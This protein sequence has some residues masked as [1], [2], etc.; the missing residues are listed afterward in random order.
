M[1]VALI[2]DTHGV[3]D[4]RI[5]E[6]VRGVDVLVHAGD[7]GASVVEAMAPLADRLVIVHGNNDPADSDWPA[8]WQLDLPGGRL[9]VIHGHQ[10]P[11][12][13]RYRKL[14]GRFTEAQA[15][16][17][18]HSHR[19]VVDDGSSPWI[20]NPG[21]AG[22]TRAYGGPG[23]IELIATADRWKVTVRDFEPVG[24]RRR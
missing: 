3:L 2:A 20:L 15:V 13:T 12:K 23:F 14:R 17:C 10:W 7:V 16:V 4:A 5:A 21:A 22:R 9:V 18:G 8:E 11:A 1:R 24:R 6:A 19:R